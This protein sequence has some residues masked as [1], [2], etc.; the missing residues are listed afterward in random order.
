MIATVVGALWQQSASAE[1]RDSVAELLT[2]SQSL[3]QAHRLQDALPIAIRAKELAETTNGA[4]SVQSGY[5]ISNLARIYAALGDWDHAIPLFTR[6]VEI[7]QALPGA[8]PAAVAATLRTLGE[9]CLAANRAESA[10]APLRQAL[11]LLEANGGSVKDGIDNVLF[12][13][14]E[15]DRRLGNYSEALQYDHR[16]LSLRQGAFGPSDKRTADG[17]RMIALDYRMAGNFGQA[18]E[19]SRQELKIR[20]T[21]DSADNPQTARS[22]IELGNALTQIASYPE[23]KEVLERA[24]AMR[25]R[26]SG[27]KTPETAEAMQLLAQVLT[28][29]GDYQAAIDL[30]SAALATQEASLGASNPRLAFPLCDLAFAYQKAGEWSQASEA[31][32]RALTISESN[33]QANSRE[34]ASALAGL[35]QIKLLLGAYDEALPLETRAITL[36]KTLLGDKHPDTLRAEGDLAHIEF[37]LGKYSEAVETYEQTLHSSESVWGPEHPEIAAILDGLGSAYFQTSRYAD[38]LKAQERSLA[39]REK[40]NGHESSLTAQSINNLAWDYALAGDYDRAVKFA[41][42]AVAID[43]RIFGPDSPQTAV[44]EGNL[45]SFLT[46]AGK[47]TEALPILQEALLTT[48]ADVGPTHPTVSKLMVDIA[49]AYY[50]LG[51]MDAAILW[52]KQAINVSQAVRSHV[53]ALGDVTLSQYTQAVARPYQTL[54]SLLVDQGRLPE[55]QVVLAMLKENEQFEFIRGSSGSDPRVFRIDF[56][57]HESPWVERFNRISANVVELSEE[58]NALQKIKP[59]DLTPAQ[60]KRLHSLT[61][62]LR[63]AEKGFHAHVAEMVTALAR[64]GKSNVSE[65]AELSSR[66]LADVQAM[67][68]DFGEG[69]V[70]L[71]YFLLEDHVGILLTTSGT[72]VA[73]SS[74]ISLKDLTRRVNAFHRDLMNPSTQITDE[75]EALY[76]VLIKPVQSDLEQAHAKTVMLSLDDVLRYIPFGALTDGTRYLVEQYSLPVYTSVAR[77]HAR[78]APK[79]L[80]H[81]AGFGVT[82]AAPGFSALPSAKEEITEIVRNGSRGVIDGA[83]YLDGAFTSQQLRAT[84]ASGI[85]VIHIASHFE[86]SPGTVANSFLLMGDDTHLSLRELLAQNFRFDNTELLT[87]SACDTALGGSRD[88]GGAEIEGFAVLAQEQGAKTV[89]ASLWQVSDASTAAMMSDMYRRLTSSSLSKA[90]ALREA[91]LTIRGNPQY[92]H[93]HYWAPFILMGN[94]Q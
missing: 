93:P 48:I 77:P 47:P 26:V 55:A 39:I 42:D 29:Q 58:R 30:F 80:Q 86:F 12:A 79:A 71:Q 76:N 78:Q 5:A 54:A 94:W 36:F 72:Q 43:T 7:A 10:G 73:R 51:K 15:V 22:L 60:S 21:V 6:Q 59:P 92:S 35:A 4:I 8:S 69:T 64:T 65:T 85:P 33:G 28:Q 52:A 61:E 27:E 41:L 53:N 44:C 91:E 67:L 13:L 87:L 3:V 62:Y 16:M 70:L 14:G 66:S 37:L 83:I 90:D 32:A 9:V 89:I 56:T 82:H 68:R 57:T 11:A 40:I 38:G 17:F 74:A 20:E 1:L 25:K 49:N 19:Y 81:A 23:A 75:S 18:V 45:G 50:S 2:E 88:D 24:L 31:Y 84:G 34:A 46:L 63:A